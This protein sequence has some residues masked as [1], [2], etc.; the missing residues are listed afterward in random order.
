MNPLDILVIEDKNKYDASIAQ[1]SDLG[2]HVDI[3]RNLVEASEFLGYQRARLCGSQISPKRY[4]VVL[5]DLM[6]PLGGSMFDIIAIDDEDQRHEEA[7]LGF[8]IVLRAA[9]QGVPYIA[10]VTDLNHH[11]GPIAASLDLLYASDDREELCKIPETQ[12]RPTFKINNSKVRLFDIRDLPALSL[13]KDG[14]I[15]EGPCNEE[16]MKLCLHPLK[17]YKAALERLMDYEGK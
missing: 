17:N 13:L 14:R 3:A 11:K 12:H 16:E 7:P 4:D 6:F 8:A 5:T 10:V 15:C 2:H 1:V 9:R